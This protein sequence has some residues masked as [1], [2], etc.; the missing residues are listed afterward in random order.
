MQHFHA[1]DIDQERLFK[2]LVMDSFLKHLPFP[3]R[4][5]LFSLFLEYFVYLSMREWR[6]ILGLYMRCLSI[7][8]YEDEYLGTYTE[9][10]NC[11]ENFSHYFG[12][13]YSTH[14]RIN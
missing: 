5:G 12:K 8:R 7:I 4:C 13:V 14:E 3:V 9:V 6:F 10:S 11:G 1:Y 2:E